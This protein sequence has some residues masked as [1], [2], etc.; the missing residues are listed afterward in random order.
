MAENMSLVRNMVNLVGCGDGSMGKILCWKWRQIFILWVLTPNDAPYC[1][2]YSVQ[3]KCCQIKPYLVHHT[4][5]VNPD[6][7]NHKCRINQR[8]QCDSCTRKWLLSWNTHVSL[9]PME[10]CCYV[11][12]R[13]T[14]LP[15][16]KRASEQI[17]R[18]VYRQSM[19]NQLLRGEFIP[20]PLRSL[21]IV[22]CR[23]S[24]PSESEVR[25][26]EANIVS[27]RWRVLWAI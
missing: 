22:E 15:I 7:K 23:T 6:W 17:L 14:A 19:L 2:R 25:S 8:N 26:K 16:F 1:V 10:I 5:Q 3:K 4:A 13:L 11:R 24:E 27:A 18:E 21:M 20:T 9:R 12:Q